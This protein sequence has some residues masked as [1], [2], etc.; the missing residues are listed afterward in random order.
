MFSC[1]APT[2]IRIPVSPMHAV[3][4]EWNFSYI[5]QE[6]IHNLMWKLKLH[7]VNRTTVLTIRR[8]DNINLV[9]TWSIN[10]AQIQYILP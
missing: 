9:Y 2:N 8:S 3:H 6:P 5:F 1:T 7:N 10:G 4:F